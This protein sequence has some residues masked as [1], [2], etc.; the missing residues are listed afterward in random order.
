MF[1]TF[2]LLAMLVFAIHSSVPSAD[3]AVWYRASISVDSTQQS[4]SLRITAEFRQEV[5]GEEWE[6][7]NAFGISWGSFDHPSSPEVAATARSFSL[8]LPATAQNV[9]ALKALPSLEIKRLAA[10]RHRAQFAVSLVNQQADAKTQERLSLALARL[11]ATELGGNTKV[12]GRVA[13]V[14]RRGTL[15]IVV[16]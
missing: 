10:G 4:P 3:A 9:E 13:S 7:L 12:S 16:D 11:V 15:T 1:K 6:S 8:I 14:S 5:T 2:A